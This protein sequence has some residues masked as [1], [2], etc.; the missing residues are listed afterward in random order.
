MITK[1]ASQFFK[2]GYGP[3]ND[4]DLDFCMKFIFVPEIILL[5]GSETF[6]PVS[7]ITS[8]PWLDQFLNMIAYLGDFLPEFVWDP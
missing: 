3:A 4:R 1:Y 6:N 2:A 5:V 8:R 7:G